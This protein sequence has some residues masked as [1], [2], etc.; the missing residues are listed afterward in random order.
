LH[1][2]G[3]K[4]AQCNGSPSTSVPNSARTIMSRDF[5]ASGCLPKKS[6]RP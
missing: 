6:L 1:P 4:I 5:L 2:H 3:M